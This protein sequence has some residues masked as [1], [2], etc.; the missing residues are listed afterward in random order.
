VQRAAETL[1]YF[2]QTPSHYVRGLERR[3]AHLGLLRAAAWFCRD[4]VGFISGRILGFLSNP[5]N[6]FSSVP[7]PFGNPNWQSLS[8][9]K[10]RKAFFSFSFADIMRVNVVRNAWKVGHPDSLVG[11]RSFYDSSLWERRQLEDPETVKR[12]I[13]EGVGYTSAVCVLVGTETALRRWVRYEIARAV[14][15]NRGLLAVHLNG[16][17]HHKLLI[18]HARG[19]NPLASMAVGKVQPDSWLLPPAYY[20]FEY[21][22][23]GWARYRDY[24]NPVSLPAYLSDPSPGYVMPLSTGTAEWDYIGNDGSKNI[25][26]W[27]DR[28]A[29]VVRR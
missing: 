5:F 22:Q 19:P 6:T 1:T 8:T 18:P 21:T 12:L 10:K 29:Q 23:Q 27:I 4:S 14:I 20:L 13:R 9:P 3:G 26:L 11:G 28:A 17:R 15:D 25:G 24:T 16:I 2:I 7:P